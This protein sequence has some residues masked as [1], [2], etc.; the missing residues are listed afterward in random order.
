MTHVLQFFILRLRLWSTAEGR[1]FSEPNIW[2]RPKVKIAPTVQHWSGIGLPLPLPTHFCQYVIYEWLPRHV[3]FFKFKHVLQDSRIF[4]NS[5]VFVSTAKLRH[6]N[7]FLMIFQIIWS[8]ERR[9]K[10]MY[11]AK[12]LLKWWL[13][14]FAKKKVTCLKN[15]M[16]L[17]P[18]LWFDIE[19]ISQKENMN[20]FSWFLFIVFVCPSLH[21]LHYEKIYQ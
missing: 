19:L 12:N 4:Q 16:G 10:I 17:M 18:V 20:N 3:E 2:L 7:V 11:E 14:E 15:T 8:E 1:S 9:K 13:I 5:T 6:V 21:S